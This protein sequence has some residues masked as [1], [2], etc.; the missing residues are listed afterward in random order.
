MDKQW[1]GNMFRLPPRKSNRSPRTDERYSKCLRACRRRHQQADSA[2]PV[3][4]GDYLQAQTIPFRQRAVDPQLNA[5]RGQ[6]VNVRCG[7]AGRDIA[8]DPERPF[9]DAWFN[10]QNRIFDTPVQQ[11]QFP[12]ESTLTRLGMGTGGVHSKR[13]SWQ[14][15]LV[16]SGKLPRSI[17]MGPMLSLPA[18]ALRESSLTRRWRLW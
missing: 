6:E 15:S 7:L 8:A 11:L 2:S 9:L 14:V 10:L 17:R 18:S 1:S 5:A 16:C 4:I 3:S 12:F 13:R